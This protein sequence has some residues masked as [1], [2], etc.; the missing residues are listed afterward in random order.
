MSE[1][2]LF[3]FGDVFELL[4]ASVAFQRSVEKLRG[5]T[6]AEPLNITKLFQVID[7]L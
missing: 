3:E 7:D 1:Q 6:L 5:F 4:L 2:M